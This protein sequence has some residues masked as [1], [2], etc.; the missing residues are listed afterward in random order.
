MTIPTWITGP[1]IFG[2]IPMANK[3]YIN[4]ANTDGAAVWEQLSLWSEY[5]A[6][7]ILA[8][9][10]DNT[11]APLTVG[12]QTV[13]GRLTGGNISAVAIGIADNNIVQIDQDGAADNDYAKFTANGIEGRSYAEVLADIVYFGSCF[14]NE[15]AWE[16]ASAAQNTWYN[17]SDSD[18]ADGSGGLNGTTHDGSGKITVAN[19]GKYLIT[20][21]A[22]IEASVANAHVKIGIEVDGSGTAVNDGLTHIEAASA[23]KQL[24]VG[25]TAILSLSASSYVE[26]SVMTDDASTPTIRV[27]HLGYSITRVG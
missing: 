9:T 22:A 16:Q 8:A 12:E 6:H 1:E 24:P 2:L 27:D 10:D 20:Y 23:N 11:P 7:T 17:I 15:I 4:A 25:G 19:T 18:M 3:V 26:I 21:Y 13:V 14:G 5:N